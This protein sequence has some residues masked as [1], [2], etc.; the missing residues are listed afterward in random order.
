MWTCECGYTSVDMRV[1]ICECGYMNAD[2]WSNDSDGDK[3]RA[4]R[5]ICPTANLSTTNPTWTSLGMRSKLS[6][7]KAT[8]L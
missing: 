8:N 3:I 6:G 4:Q 2:P 5:K 1:W 7:E